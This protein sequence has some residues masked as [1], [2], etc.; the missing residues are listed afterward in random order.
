MGVDVSL[1]DAALQK[2]MGG[3]PKRA[4]AKSAPA[5]GIK[6]HSAASSKGKQ[7]PSTPA[8]K[9]KVSRKYKVRSAD[10][11]KNFPPTEPKSSQEKSISTPPKK[12]WWE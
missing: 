1:A 7:T 8:K 12:S 11:L 6:I 2:K 4:T 10:S 3:S 5:S 9:T